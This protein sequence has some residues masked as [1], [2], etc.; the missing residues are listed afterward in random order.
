MNIQN[1]KRGSKITLYN[2][3]YAILL[4]LFYIFFGKFILK[5]NLKVVDSFWQLF[6][7]Y[8]PGLAYM[9]ILIN[10]LLGLLLLSFGI[11]TIYLS[12]FIIKRKDKF[13]WVILFISGL[14]TWAGLLT[15]NFLIKNLLMIILAFVGWIIFIIGMV[16]PIRYYLQ[17]S[18][19]DF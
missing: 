8:N 17:K 5:G 2:G 11:M 16:L 12:I 19:P 7:K 13:A 14:I 15:I 18:Y 3:V 4:S 10:I 9:L 6:S 1:V